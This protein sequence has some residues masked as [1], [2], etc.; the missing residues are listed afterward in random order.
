MHS[1]GKKTVASPL[2]IVRPQEEEEPPMTKIVSKKICQ[3]AL[4]LTLLALSFVLPACE[5][6][7]NPRLNQIAI[8]ACEILDPAPGAALGANDDRDLAASDIQIDVAVRHANAP[9]GAMLAL[10]VNGIEAKSAPL[11]DA[12][13]VFRF[14]NVTL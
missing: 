2:P 4:T 13:G 3:R 11:A 1:R 5:G 7:F 10:S 6:Y 8:T 9:A 12:T 14:S